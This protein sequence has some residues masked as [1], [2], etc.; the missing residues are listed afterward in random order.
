MNTDSSERPQL[1]FFVG[2]LVLSII[3][4]WS[5]WLA[6]SWS[7][8]HTGKSVASSGFLAVANWCFVWSAIGKFFIV[9][10]PANVG[11]VTKDQFDG[12][13]RVYR[14]GLHIVFPWEIRPFT[15]FM[16]AEAI[17]VVI[18]EQFPTKDGGI[19]NVHGS[20]IYQPALTPV[21]NE[22]IDDADKRFIRYFLTEEATIVTSFYNHIVSLIRHEITNMDTAS[23]RQDLN[24]ID[25]RIETVTSKGE[26]IE[27]FEHQYGVNFINLELATFDFDMATQ[28]TLAAGFSAQHLASTMDPFAKL[29]ES[30]RQ[31]A[32]V[33]LGRIKKDVNDFKLSLTG[34]D[35]EVVEAVLAQLKRLAKS[36]TGDNQRL[37]P[38]PPTLK[39]E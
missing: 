24:T 6:L 22:S 25:E 12:I 5:I 1:T 16:S 34:L 31:D 14:Q 8:A 23:L 26:G 36:K 19:V 9:S 7:V 33:L 2:C 32:L 20:F 11:L 29:G 21:G 10:V 17:T 39:P 15:H 27:N 38:S 13:L 18:N 28:N 4:I 37:P 30:E 3:S 35:P